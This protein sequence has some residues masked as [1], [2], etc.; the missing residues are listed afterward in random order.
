M[1][2]AKLLSPKAGEE[3]REGANNFPRGAKAG[4]VRGEVKR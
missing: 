1:F 4:P 2:S 3:R